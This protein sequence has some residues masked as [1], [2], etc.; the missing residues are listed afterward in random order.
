VSD[1]YEMTLDDYFH[2][3]KWSWKNY[4]HI[5]C[6]ILHALH[7]LQ[8]KTISFTDFK[9]NN[10]MINKNTLQVYL[11][12][13]FNSPYECDFVDCDE[14]DNLNFTYYN[15]FYNKMN[16]HQ[17][18]F[19][20][21]I[22]MLHAIEIRNK[23]QWKLSKVIGD[24]VSETYYEKKQCKK[25]LFLFE[26]CDHVSSKNEFITSLQE[27]LSHFKTHMQHVKQLSSSDKHHLY[28]LVEKC[29]FI[30]PKKPFTI[31]MILQ[32]PFFSKCKKQQV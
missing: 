17:D 22:A 4:K 27:Y 20:I 12:D 23:G 21:G 28:V 26:D 3:E 32:N 16:F 2:K 13:Y 9:L 31:P 25:W 15:V 29:L 14:D 30:D 18:I 8:S 5:F 10:V 19:R 7:Y 1:L 24:I 11:I 6:Q